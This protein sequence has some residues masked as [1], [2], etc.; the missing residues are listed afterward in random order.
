VEQEKLL[1]K[2]FASNFFP[3]LSFWYFERKWRFE[4]SKKNYFIG[5]F[6]GVEDIYAS[7]FNPTLDEEMQAMLDS[8]HYRGDSQVIIYLLFFE[9]LTC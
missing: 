2:S 9:K 3:F 4:E 5:T 8:G 1:L 6:S 7:D